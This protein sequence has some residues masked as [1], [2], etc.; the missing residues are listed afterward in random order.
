MLYV[1][2]MN[3]FFWQHADFSG[4]S[5]EMSDNSAKSTVQRYLKLTFY[6]I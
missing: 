1:G 5:P 2:I 3:N 6:S 4:M